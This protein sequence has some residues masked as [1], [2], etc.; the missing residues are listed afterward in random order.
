M[1]RK[2]RGL[3]PVIATILLIAIAVVLALI[4][5]TFAKNYVREKTEK[6]GQPIEDSCLNVDFIAEAVSGSECTP[7]S[8]LDRVD[9]NNNGNVPLY[10]VEI[11][12]EGSGAVRSLGTGYFGDGLPVG[13]GNCIDIDLEG[14]DEIL[15]VPI[16]LGET[17][18]FKKP[19]TCGN[20]F[21]KFANVI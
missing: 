18:D 12:E 1:I 13:S 2:K 10:G 20:D 4:V 6:F 3:S 15:V 7:G 11:R 17:E 8:G 19:Y 16:L 5:F 9:V 21:G 14:G